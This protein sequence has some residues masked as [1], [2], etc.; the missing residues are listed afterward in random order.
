MKKGVVMLNNFSG[1]APSN[2]QWYN[3]NQS[4]DT[5]MHSDMER[6]IDMSFVAVGFYKGHLIGMA[7]KKSSEQV[8]GVYCEDIYKPT[9]KKIWA[10]DNDMIIA[11]VGKNSFFVDDPE[12]KDHSKTAYLDE[13][14]EKEISLIPDGEIVCKEI[15]KYLMDNVKYGFDSVTAITYYVQNGNVFSIDFSFDKNN[16]RLVKQLHQD[17]LYTYNG[18]PEY[19]IYFKKHIDDFMTLNRDDLKEA[20]GRMNAQY[21]KDHPNEYD[22]VGDEWDIIVL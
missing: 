12:D 2:N 10:V 8:A 16:Y 9:V 18:V 21:K 13:I 1:V 22:P 6:Q 20:L 14:I 15:Y 11:F 4:K 3:Q 19:G 5:A 17:W 7:D